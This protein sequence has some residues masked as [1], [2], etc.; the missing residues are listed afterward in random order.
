MVI[1]IGGTSR[2]GKTLLSQKL[3]EKYKF[4]YMSIDHIKMGVFRGWVNC[5]YT[6]ESKD[7]VIT[8]K[9]WS[10]IKGIIMTNIE[11]NQNIIIEGVNLPFF[12]FFMETDY[13]SKII[14]C[15]ICFSEE[16]IKNYLKTKIIKYEN[17]IENRGYDFEYLINEFIEDNKIIIKKCKENNI[18]YFEINENYE[19]EIKCVYEWLDSEI[20]KL[21]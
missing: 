6:P 4:P 7:E 17:I 8:E 14:F 19:K 20:Y 18:K 11:N 5:G 21:M 16:Y 15:K 13:G 12:F 2:A 3:M 9:L 10:I 1:L